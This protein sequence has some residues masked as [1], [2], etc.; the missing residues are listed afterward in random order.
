VAGQVARRAA[1]GLA[2]GRQAEGRPCGRAG[3]WHCDMRGLDRPGG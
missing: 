2:C 3:G 1:D